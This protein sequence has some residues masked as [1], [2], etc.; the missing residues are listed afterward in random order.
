MSSLKASVI[1]AAIILSSGC[2]KQATGQSVAVVNDEE[3]SQA[4]LNAELAAA[5]VPQNADTKK[6]LPQLLQRVVDRR[7][8]AQAAIEEGLDR[9][10]EYLTRQRRANEDLL[11]G[12]S[13]KR[14][15]DSIK[16][17]TQTE[18]DKF[19][20]ENPSLFQQR[21]VLSLN[22]LVFDPPADMTLLNQLKNDHSLEAVSATLQRLR[23]PFQR[24]Q[25][26]LDTGTIPPA[27][28]K[29]IAALP[30]GE[31]FVVPSNGKIVVSVI[32]GREAAGTSVEQSRKQAA[33]LIK[34]RKLSEIMQSRLKELR[35]AAKISYQ[36]GYA[37]PPAAK[38]EASKAS[39]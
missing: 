2:G 37:P 19:I 25:A 10:P 33:E 38:A 23:I 15:A 6:V 14:R 30:P 36:E 28:A 12:M 26:K 39:K 11:I 4:E 13:M 34:Q 7:L 3:V 24:S 16:L 22:Q 31:P 18:I 9:N 17:P 1:V 29:Q 8:L 20:A 27:V 5:N 32:T 35:S 21:S